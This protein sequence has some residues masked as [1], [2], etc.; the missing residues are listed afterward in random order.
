[1]VYEEVIGNPIV[2]LDENNKTIEGVLLDIEEGVY[3]HQF[4]IK[5]LDG[6]I[7]VLGNQTVLAT[8]IKK[9][10][11]GKKLKIDYVGKVNSK[12]SKFAYSDYKVFVEK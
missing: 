2:K 12:K 6:N 9:D 3:G 1:M 5:K 7:V 10:F 4:K 8:K 11:I